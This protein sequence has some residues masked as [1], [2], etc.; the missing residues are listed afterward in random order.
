MAYINLYDCVGDVMNKEKCIRVMCSKAVQMIMEDGTDAELARKLNTFYNES[1]SRYFTQVYREV[2][3]DSP[4]VHF[5]WLDTGCTDVSGDTLYCQFSKSAFGWQGA[6]IGTENEITFNQ[7]G[8]TLK[9][10]SDEASSVMGESKESDDSAEVSSDDVMNSSSSDDIED[11]TDRVLSSL[12]CESTAQFYTDLFNRLLIQT[13]WEL[14]NNNLRNYIDLLIS[15]LNKMISDSKDVSRYLIW[16]RGSKKVLV[17]SAL[18]DKFGKIIMFV[19]DVHKSGNT[20]SFTRLQLVDSKKMLLDNDFE[21]SVLSEEI[22]CVPFYDKSVSELV[23]DASVEDFDLENWDR[24]SHC[25][26]DRRSRFPE[27]WCNS[28]TE[29]LCQDVLNAIELGV[30]LSRYDSNYIKPFYSRKRD[31]IQFII[32]YHVGNNFQEKPQLGIVVDKTEYGL[33]QVM[34]IL[35]YNMSCMNIKALSLYSDNSF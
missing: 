9:Q 10:L 24:L 7:M 22:E 16:N 14:S 29:Q 32:P 25:I 4:Y 5:M 8:K 23:F 34:T 1:S 6:F 13:G 19:S 30:R 17:N 20:L 12:D 21:K 28:S 26:I 11:A 35:D 27:P 15:R 18:L 3:K 31:K 2:D 33:W